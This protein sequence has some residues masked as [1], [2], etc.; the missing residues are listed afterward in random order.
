MNERDTHPETKICRVKVRERGR[1]RGK[2]GKRHASRERAHRKTER[3]GGQE[4]S[5]GHA[6]TTLNT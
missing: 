4:R 3:G 6:H 5:G 1:G 2:N